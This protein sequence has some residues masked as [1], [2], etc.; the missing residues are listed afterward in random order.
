MKGKVKLWL[1]DERCMGYQKSHFSVIKMVNTTRW[2]VGGWMSTEDVNTAIQQG[3]EVIISR[4][5]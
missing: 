5:R 4:K 3:V 2:E 1:S